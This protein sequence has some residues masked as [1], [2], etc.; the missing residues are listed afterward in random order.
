M[1]VVQDFIDEN[2]LP[3]FMFSVPTTEKLLFSP[4]ILL[5]AHVA[6]AH[7]V[8]SLSTHQTEKPFNRC[9]CSRDR[10]AVEFLYFQFC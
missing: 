8:L 9:V 3:N 5:S 10:V 4:V 7:T 6:S 1:A 2:A